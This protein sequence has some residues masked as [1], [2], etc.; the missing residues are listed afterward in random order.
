MAENFNNYLVSI[1]FTS[2]NKVVT[3]VPP[4]NTSSDNSL[5]MS[6]QTVNY[7]NGSRTSGSTAQIHSIYLTK[8]DQNAYS[9]DPE[10]DGVNLSIGIFDTVN[11]KEYFI[12]KFIK[13][14]PN[15]SFYIEK[16][17]T[18][19]PQ[20]SIRLTYHGS[21]STTIDAVCSGVDLT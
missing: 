19:R 17:I 18:L 8:S 13:V 15:S 9:T 16:T 12:A 1:P 7:A 4:C 11:N 5:P 2:S 6:G 14:L 21:A 10:T 3:I 20:D